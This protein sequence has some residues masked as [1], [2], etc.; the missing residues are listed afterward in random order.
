V[1]QS[2]KSEVLDNDILAE[3][4]SNDVFAYKR[5]DVQYCVPFVGA[6]GAGLLLG[7]SG[8]CPARSGQKGQHVLLWAWLGGERMESG[9]PSPLTLSTGPLRAGVPDGDVNGCGGIVSA[10]GTWK[11]HN[12]RPESISVQRI[13]A[14]L[15]GGCWKWGSAREIHQRAA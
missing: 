8:R 11:V 9:F 14:E 15:R 7:C 3:T 1:E 2:Y 10:N 13:F 12:Y 4:S 6:W 5:P